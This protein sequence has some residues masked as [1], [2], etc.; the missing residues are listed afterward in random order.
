MINHFLIGS[1]KWLKWM[2]AG[3]A[4]LLFLFIAL[5]IMLKDG[6]M[7]SSHGGADMQA[8]ESA[9]GPHGGRFFGDEAFQCEV[10]IYEPEGIPPE[11]RVYFYRNGK[12]LSPEAVKLSITLERVN[13]TEIVRFRQQDDYLLGDLTVVEPHSFHA[14]VKAEYEGKTHEWKFDSIEGRTEMTAEAVSSAKIELLKVGPRKIKE[15]L[16]LRGSVLPNGDLTF[17]AIARFPGIIRELPKK[18]GDRAEKGDV[19]AVVESQQSLQT[20]VI[21]SQVSGTVIKRNATLGEFVDS[22][23][24]LFV[25]SDLSS[26][27]VDFNVYQKDAGK[28]RNGQPVVMETVEG[29][30]AV[31]S[32]LDQVSPAGLDESRTC[33]ARSSITN[34]EGMLRPGMHVQGT[35]TVGEVDAPLAVKASALQTFRDWDVVFIRV[36][37]LFEAAPVAIGQRDDAWVEIKEGLPPD[38]EYAADNSFIVKA[39]VMKS[40]ATHDH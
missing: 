17:Q 3:L 10:T 31:H 34:P 25:V 29:S 21:R 9:R 39:D 30:L 32:T 38:S 27:W 5:K 28:I 18:M 40:G 4:I 14:F 35:I 15:T 37:A 1:S 36:G 24:V 33:L 13:R 16:S 22:E 11:F 20:Y 8:E 6:S 7:S 12:P 2:A 19:L 23:K 26:L